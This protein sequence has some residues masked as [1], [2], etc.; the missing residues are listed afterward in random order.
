MPA[1][2]TPLPRAL[3]IAWGVETAPTRGPRRGLSHDAIV[4]SAIDL[5]DAGGL[6]AVTMARVAEALGFTTMSLYRYVTSKEEL[7]VLMQDAAATHPRE[8]DVATDDWRQGLRDVAHLQLDV[9]AR[10]PW[11]LD[12]PLSVQGVLMPNAMRFADATYRAMRTLP[13]DD[14][15]KQSVLLS[16]S[17]FVRVF[18]QLRRDLGAAGT[19]DISPATITLLAQVVTPER[20]PDLAPVFRSGGYTGEDPGGGDG[21]DDFA[22]GLELFL[23]GLDAH[24]SRAAEGGG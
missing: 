14:A 11:I 24:V 22:V 15:L 9:F 10:H 16:L 2:E 18:G 12:V 19:P 3:G 17:M 21:T 20:Y 13:A 8:L 23:D 7:V 1:E 6:G 5:A 4:R